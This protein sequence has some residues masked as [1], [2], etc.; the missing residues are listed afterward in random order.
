MDM[1][2]EPKQINVSGWMIASPTQTKAKFKEK[3]LKITADAANPTILIFSSDYKWSEEGN[4][5]L[6]NW[7]FY[8]EINDDSGNQLYSD[9]KNFGEDTPIFVEDKK[10]QKL[11]YLSDNDNFQSGDGTI[12]KSIRTPSA[13]GKYT[14]TCLIRAQFWSRKPGEPKDRLINLTESKSSCTVTVTVR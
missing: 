8:M 1:S 9:S 3:E 2:K 12:V 4:T 14:Y 6:N 7:D 10:L 13:T 11:D 5:D